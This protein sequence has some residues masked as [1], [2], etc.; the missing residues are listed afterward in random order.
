MVKPLYDPAIHAKQTMR[1]RIDPRLDS[2]APPAEELVELVQSIR[3]A[4]SEDAMAAISSM[5]S[6]AKTVAYAALTAVQA[7]ETARA[8]DRAGIEAHVDIVVAAKMAKATTDITTTITDHLEKQDD[9]ATKRDA[10]VDRLIVLVSS[11]REIEQ[12]AELAALEVQ[13]KR[14]SVNQMHVT[15]GQAFAATASLEVATEETKKK[16]RWAWVDHYSGVATLVTILV[17]LIVALGTAAGISQCSRTHVTAVEK[18]E[19]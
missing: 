12:Q 9:A 17:S 1:T 7:L 5:A 3:P 19:P 16:S 8:G 6:E 13:A 4:S 11:K 15:T 10:K 14:A 2:L 18:H